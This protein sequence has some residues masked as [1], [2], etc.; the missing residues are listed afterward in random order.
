MDSNDIA[1]EELGVRALPPD[2][3]PAQRAR[4][5]AV[6]R[7]AAADQPCRCSG[8]GCQHGQPCQERDDCDGRY[9]HT[10]RYPGSILERSAWWDEYICDTCECG[11]DRNV[12]LPEIPWG[13][14]VTVDG[15]QATRTYPGVRHPSFP[16][17]PDAEDA[18]P[19]CHECLVDRHRLCPYADIGDDQPADDPDYEL[20]EMSCCCGREWTERPL[21]TAA[22]YAAY[23]REVTER[24]GY[25]QDAREG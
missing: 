5:E 21:T 12:S 8:T 13:E 23:A 19:A 24:Y 10:D 15:R 9:I 1:A 2:A 22:E 17:H 11:Y 14:H 4:A 18:T 6:W 3:S 20:V 25:D 7:P 16:D